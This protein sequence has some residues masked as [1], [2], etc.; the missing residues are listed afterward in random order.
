MIPEKYITNK[1]FGNNP[2]EIEG[3]EEAINDTEEL[4]IP[5]HVLEWKFSSSELKAMDRYW[6][7]SK[8]EL[9]WIPRS[10][11]NNNEIL[12]IEVERKNK[13]HSVIMRGKTLTKEAKQKISKARKGHTVSEK[14]RNKIAKAITG[15]TLSTETK[16]KISSSKIGTKAWNEGKSFSEFGIKFREH[17]GINPTEDFLLYNKERRRYLRHGKC[18]WEV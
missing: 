11:H 1:C 8:E 14:T 16:N 3:Y 15:K 4:Y 6:E 5:H 12:H 7:V 9:I 13:K 17:F 2:E 18:S 10:V